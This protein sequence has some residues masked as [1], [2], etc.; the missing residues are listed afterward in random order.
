MQWEGTEFTDLLDRLA[1]EGLTALAAFEAGVSEEFE[2]MLAVAEALGVAD[3][4]D[5]R[6]QQLFI[7]I[8][9]PRCGGA[10]RA[11]LEA[12]QPALEELSAVREALAEARHALLFWASDVRTQVCR[13]NEAMDEEEYLCGRGINAATGTPRVNSLAD[14]TAWARKRLAEALK[15]YRATFA[16]TELAEHTV[17]RLRPRVALVAV[18]DHAALALD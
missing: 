9:L 18:G 8:D 1:T 7:T 3:L 12:W 2:D 17:A 11:L 4:R 5:S 16:R 13:L 15:T 10:L 6:V 14:D